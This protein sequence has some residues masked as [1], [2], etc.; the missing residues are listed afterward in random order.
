[1][2]GL[3]QHFAAGLDNKAG[4]FTAADNA[5]CNVSPHLYNIVCSTRAHT[6]L[7]IMYY[8][9]RPGAFPGPERL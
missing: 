6:S 7:P 1:M 8:A 9:S 5:C 2:V 4:L 3:S